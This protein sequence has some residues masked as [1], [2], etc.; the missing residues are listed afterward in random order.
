M[1]EWEANPVSTLGSIVTCCGF[2]YFLLKLLST[3]NTNHFIVRK[4]K[5]FPTMKIGK[6]SHFDKYLLYEQLPA[7]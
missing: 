4:T 1:E 2:N 6:S 7:T 3:I 5:V